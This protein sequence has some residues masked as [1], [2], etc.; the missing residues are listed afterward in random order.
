M[1][2]PPRTSNANL[3]PLFSHFTNALA[4]DRYPYLTKL[5][6]SYH[7]KEILGQTYG[8]MLQMAVGRRVVVEWTPYRDSEEDVVEGQEEEE[9]GIVDPNMLGPE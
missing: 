1:V 8:G 6:G 4:N 3:L 2:L 7:Y 9:N 5:S